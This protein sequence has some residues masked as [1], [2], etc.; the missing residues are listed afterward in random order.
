M[1]LLQLLA[2]FA[3]A[4]GFILTTVKCSGHCLQRVW[5]VDEVACGGGCL[6]IGL[7]VDMIAC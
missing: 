6:L 5:S 2:R 1:F 7:S 4:V 3:C